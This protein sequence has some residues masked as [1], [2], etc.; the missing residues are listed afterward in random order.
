MILLVSNLS[1]C[2]FKNSLNGFVFYLSNDFS[3]NCV[4]KS[5]IQYYFENISNCFSNFTL[6][7]KYSVKIISES[8]SPSFLTLSC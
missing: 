3:F 6:I 2:S 4:D 7:L 5:H 1:S 8:F